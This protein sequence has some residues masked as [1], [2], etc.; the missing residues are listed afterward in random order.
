MDLYESCVRDVV[1]QLSED[2]DAS[3]PR[4]ELAIALVS[5]FKQHGQPWYEYIVLNQAVGKV[6]GKTVDSWE[7]LSSL[8]KSYIAAAQ[9]R[10]AAHVEIPVV[11]FVRY[12]SSHPHQPA[13]FQLLL[14]ERAPGP[15]QVSIPTLSRDYPVQSSPANLTG[16]TSESAEDTMES[17]GDNPPRL[18]ETAPLAMT[19][20]SPE[21][22]EPAICGGGAS[23]ICGELPPI[24]QSERCSVSIS[25]PIV[26]ASSASSPDSPS[27]PKGVPSMTYDSRPVDFTESIGLISWKVIAYAFLILATFQLAD[28]LLAKTFVQFGELISHLFDVNS[29]SIR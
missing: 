17:M 8:Y 18:Q 9:S 24:S 25:K 5:A 7:S 20:T 27:G 13:V 21:T 16:S 23:E 6:V 22:A 10:R 15:G 28:T 1:A 4:V 26:S 11:C 19:Q 3:D 2:R 14:R 29:W 12:R